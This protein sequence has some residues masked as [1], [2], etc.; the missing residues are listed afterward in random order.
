MHVLPMYAG[1][2]CKHHALHYYTFLAVAIK[3]EVYEMETVVHLNRNLQT[4][5]Q[6]YDTFK[7]HT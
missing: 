1:K 5:S 3:G 2:N 7:M 6:D 4:Y